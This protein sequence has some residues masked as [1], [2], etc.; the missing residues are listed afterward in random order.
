MADD[1]APGTAN[2]GSSGSNGDMSVREL[3]ELRE[4]LFGGERRQLDE[5]RRRLDTA[6][7][8]PEEL[9]EK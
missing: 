2:A 9:A 6:E 1:G 3:T 5:L 4:L 7:L 8:S